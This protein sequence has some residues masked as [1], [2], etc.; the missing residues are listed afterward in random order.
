LS[1]PSSKPG[2]SVVSSGF[3][4]KFMG[5]RSERETPLEEKVAFYLLDFLD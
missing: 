4:Q 2:V 5:V 3:L 1:K